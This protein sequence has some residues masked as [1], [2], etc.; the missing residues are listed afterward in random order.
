MSGDFEKKIEELFL[1]NSISIS[2]EQLE[3]ILRESFSQIHSKKDLYLAEM[4]MRYQKK[5]IDH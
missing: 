3:N 1:G 4:A 5:M 2:A